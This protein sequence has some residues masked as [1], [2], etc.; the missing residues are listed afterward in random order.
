MFP[1]STDESPNTIIAGTTALI[2]RHSNYRKGLWEEIARKDCENGGFTFVME[3]RIIQLFSFAFIISVYFL[4]RD[5]GNLQ[6]LKHENP[7]PPEECSNSSI[8][9][10][11]ALKFLSLLHGCCLGIFSF[12]SSNTY[13]FPAL[14]LRVLFT[15]EETCRT[16]KS[17]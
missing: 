3:N 10:L 1:E 16:S 5:S 12:W 17:V 15:N 7:P 9:C 2:L 8:N 6:L 11:A 13:S 4:I 14:I